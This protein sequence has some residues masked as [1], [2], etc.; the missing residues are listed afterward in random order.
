MVSL[1]PAGIEHLNQ[2]EMLPDFRREFVRITGDAPTY[3]EHYWVRHG[4][5]PGSLL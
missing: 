2:Y 3:G 1:T 5:I 4:W